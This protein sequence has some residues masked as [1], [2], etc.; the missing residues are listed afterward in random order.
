MKVALIPLIFISLFF[1]SLLY[2]APDEMDAKLT[3]GGYFQ[4]WF[5]Y[6]QAE[7]GAKQDYT[8]D[9]GAQ[10]ASGFNLNRARG[11]ARMEWR[12]FGAYAQVRLE[13]GSL[14]LLDAYGYW[15][16]FGKM[17]EVDVGQMKIPSVWEVQVPDESLD[18]FSRSRFASEVTNWSLSKSTFSTSPLYFIQ[19]NL[20][21][22]GAGIRGEFRGLEYFLMV[23]NGL[24]ANA[25]IGAIENRQFVYANP[26]G[27]YFYG[28]RL[29]YD[30]FNELGDNLW[31][32]PCALAIGGHYNLNDHSNL[33]YNDARTVLDLKRHSWSVDAR[34]RLF[35]RVRVTG[36]Y[37]EGVVDDDFDHDGTPDYT[38]RGWEIGAVFTLVEDTLEA[39]VRYDTYSSNIAV[40]SGWATVNAVT[41]GLTYSLKPHLRTMIDFKWKQQTGDL[42]QAM[43][44][45]IAV[46]VVQFGL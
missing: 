12:D 9:P 27:A 45:G 36:M 1:A 16:P 35:D 26:F 20:R 41:V 42:T 22:L 25:Y 3:F 46:A 17:L 38:Y 7:N 34:L 23:G 11:N 10:E 43:A 21:D 13:G 19:T 44:N 39:G 40:T 15:R 30:V 32:V 29:S 24:G 8:A 33:I 14:S 28:G 6:E 4:V 31:G 5:Q 37:G 2:A 18:F